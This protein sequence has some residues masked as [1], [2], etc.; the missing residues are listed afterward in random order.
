[1]KWAPVIV[2]GYFGSIAAHFLINGRYF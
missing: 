2:L 1:L